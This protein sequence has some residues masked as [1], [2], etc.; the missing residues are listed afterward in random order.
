MIPATPRSTPKLPA[1][2]VAVRFDGAKTDKTYDYFS[3]LPLEVG[4]KVIVETFRGE[5]AAIVAEIKTHSDKAEKF[6]VG[7]N[8]GGTVE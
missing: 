7:M 5:A 6:V 1:I 2:V 3:T 4:D 8:D